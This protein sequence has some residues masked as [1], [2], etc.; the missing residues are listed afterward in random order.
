M[1]GRG[2][3]G[4]ER[5]R[6]ES[7]GGRGVQK[8]RGGVTRRQNRAETGEGSGPRGEE[9]RINF[10][11]RPRVLI[12]N[13]SDTSTAVPSAHTRA[14][15]HTNI[16]RSCHSNTAEGPACTHCGWGNRPTNKSTVR[17]PIV[18]LE[19]ALIRPLALH[20]HRAGRQRGKEEEEEEKEEEEEGEERRA[21]LFHLCIQAVKQ[22]EESQGRNVG[23][24]SEDTPL[25]PC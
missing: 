3:G 15:N 12:P 22:H 2:E 13:G 25:P 4:G 24:I 11:S 19:R 17:A 16:D 14:H 6:R 10:L 21:M 20:G 1:K 7:L 8:E 23:L 9:S 5:G 18:I